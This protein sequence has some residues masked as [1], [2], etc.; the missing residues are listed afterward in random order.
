MLFLR[1]RSRAEGPCHLRQHPT[2]FRRSRCQRCH[3]V[4]PGTGGCPLPEIWRGAASGQGADEQQKRLLSEPQ[5]WYTVQIIKQTAALR[6]A[7]CSC[8]QKYGI[9]RAERSWQIFEI[10]DRLFALPINLFTIL[11][12]MPLI[13]SHPLDLF[14]VSA[15]R[16][17]DNGGFLAYA[18]SPLLDIFAIFATINF[19][20]LLCVSR[21]KWKTFWLLCRESSFFFFSELK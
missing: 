14:R 12:I 9:F 1:H 4:P 5:L 6:A 19:G 8:F 16:L 18:P 2:P 3:Q 21:M 7:V 10:I 11:R 20:G 17:D 15:C 13:N